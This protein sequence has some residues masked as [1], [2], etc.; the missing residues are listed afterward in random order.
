MAST[1]PRAFDLLLV[2][3]PVLESRWAQPQRVELTANVSADRGQATL[4][5]L[6]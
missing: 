1:K 2:E 3:P 4:D 5:D 6:S